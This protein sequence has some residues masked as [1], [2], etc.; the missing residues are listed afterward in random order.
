MYLA[1]TRV[2]GE[3]YRKRLKSLLLYLCDVFRAL[4][5]SLCVDFDYEEAGLT[6]DQTDKKNLIGMK[7]PTMAL[8]KDTTTERRCA[9]QGNYFYSQGHVHP[10]DFDKISV[11]FQHT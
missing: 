9:E 2:P 11:S 8:T 5:N 6:L 10:L 4:I 7:T 3:S 1:F